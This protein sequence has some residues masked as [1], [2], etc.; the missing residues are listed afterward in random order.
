MATTFRRWGWASTAMA[1]MAVLLVLSGNGLAQDDKGMTGHW[2][3][4]DGATLA[5]RQVG[6]E[7]Y[8]VARSA[9]GGKEWTHVFHGTIAGKRLTGTWADVPPG[10]G[11]NNGTF[12]FD[13]LREGGKV[14]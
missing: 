12:K 9:D 4:P 5:A 2:F 7:V 1:S 3:H 8:W 13:L 14:V 10:K 11:R 6:K